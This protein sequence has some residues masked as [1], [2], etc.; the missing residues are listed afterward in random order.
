[1]RGVGADVVPIFPAAD[2]LLH[3]ML[4]RARDGDGFLAVGRLEDDLGDDEEFFEVHAGK[5][6][7]CFAGKLNIGFEALTN[8]LIATCLFELFI[9]S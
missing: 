7:F 4:F 8:F 1:M 6:G 5:L 9:N 3:P 2:A